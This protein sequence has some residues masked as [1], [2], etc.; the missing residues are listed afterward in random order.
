MRHLHFAVMSVAKKKLNKIKHKSLVIPSFVETFIGHIVAYIYI[1]IYQF[2]MQI[3]FKQFVLIQIQLKLPIV[4]RANYRESLNLSVSR[5]D[6]MRRTHLLVHNFSEQLA[7]W[8]THS[9]KQQT[10]KKTMN[11]NI[12]QCNIDIGN[13]HDLK[14]VHKNGIQIF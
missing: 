11:M 12:M 10:R 6:L 3:T 8:R 5:V 7:I 9:Q 4:W 14:F 13:S 2:H 1:Y